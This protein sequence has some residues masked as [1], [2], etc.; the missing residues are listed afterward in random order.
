MLKLFFLPGNSETIIVKRKF[1]KKIGINLIKLGLLKSSPFGCVP[2][3]IR[4]NAAEVSG[5]TK[6]FS[7]SK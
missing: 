2:T 1:L 5:K 3:N 7:F 4:Q 6:K